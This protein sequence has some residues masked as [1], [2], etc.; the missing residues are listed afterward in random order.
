MMTDFERR[1]WESR[2]SAEGVTP[3]LALKAAIEEVERI[4]AKHV[5]IVTIEDDGEGGDI[6]GIMQAGSLS[7]LAT[8]G[9]LSRA[10]RIS[11]QE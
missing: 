2:K 1:L 7:V 5:I 6:I 4:K 8:E 3:T 11:S 9:A 10:A